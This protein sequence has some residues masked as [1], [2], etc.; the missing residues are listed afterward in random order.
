MPEDLDGIVER[1]GDF[2]VTE[3]KLILEGTT[4]RMSVE[5]KGAVLTL[6]FLRN[7]GESYTKSQLTGQALDGGNV[8]GALDKAR[9]LLGM[10]KHYELIT[11]GYA[12]KKYGARQINL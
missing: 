9:S 4:Q 7:E 10:S 3:D 2:V 11:E 12:P 1:H 5:T 8:N 6:Y